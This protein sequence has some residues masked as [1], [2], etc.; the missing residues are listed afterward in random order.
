MTYSVLVCD[1]EPEEADGWLAAVRTVASTETYDFRNTPTTE[2][3]AHAVKTLLQRRRAAHEGA[4]KPA[5]GCIF[6]GVDVLIVDYDLLHIDENNARYTGEGVARL[7]R[8][9]ADCGAVVVLNQ[10]PEAQFDLSLKGHLSSHADL[11]IDVDLLATAGLWEPPPWEG[12]RPWSWQRLSEAAEK[13]RRRSEALAGTGLDGSIVDFLGMTPEDAARLSDTA[14]GF[15]AP[16]AGD[17]AALM[18]Q[19]FRGF[20]D[21]SPDGRDAAA[22]INGDLAAAA[23]F[24]SARVAK[25]LER[26]VLGPQDVL[27]DIPH[28]LQRFPFLV[29]GDVADPQAWNEAIHDVDSVKAAL[30]DGVWFE[31]ADWL[32]KPAVWW[33]RLEV[34]DD[35]RKKR[36]EFDYSVVPPIA[37]MEDVSAFCPMD[38]AREFR[39][40]FHN[41]FDRRFVKAVNGIRYAPQRR[42]AFGA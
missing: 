34:N 26:E 22:L 2:E 5:D 25:W 1:D 40:G 21:Q 4:A 42:F 11:N 27:V 8:T 33:R 15:L 37:F 36:L 7:A 38:D 29:P 19:S 17:F 13:Q 30:P 10:Y 6:D 41:A 3:A 28:L 16:E 14:F 39:A 31:H 32:S 35:I 9:Y 12:F 23:R 24:V 18:T 20:L